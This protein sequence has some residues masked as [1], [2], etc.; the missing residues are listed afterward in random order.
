MLSYEGTVL[1]LSTKYQKE[2]DSQQYTTSHQKQTIQ[3]PKYAEK[4]MQN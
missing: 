1:F 3:L 4:S 2:F